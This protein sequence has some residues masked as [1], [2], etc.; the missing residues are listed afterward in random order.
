MR[1]SHGSE[2]AR[3]HGRVALSYFRVLFACSPIS[4]ANS[5]AVIATDPIQDQFRAV[6]IALG[7]MVKHI[8]TVSEASFN[9]VMH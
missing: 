2:I 5:H 4:R 1:R 3:H 8:R 9:F 7:Y 6:I